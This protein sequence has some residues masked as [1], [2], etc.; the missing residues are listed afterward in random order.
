MQG[1]CLSTRCTRATSSWS[2]EP[3]LLWTLWLQAGVVLIPCVVGSGCRAA[4]CRVAWTVGMCLTGGSLVS[5]AYAR[6]CGCKQGYCLLCVRRVPRVVH[7]HPESHGLSAS[8][9][10]RGQ[11]ETAKPCMQRQ[12]MYLSLSTM[13]CVTFLWCAGVPTC[14]SAT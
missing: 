8:C 6:R 10:G 9:A 4:A 3:S 12:L 2:G 14:Q 1:R 11:G 13:C 5:P 7:Q